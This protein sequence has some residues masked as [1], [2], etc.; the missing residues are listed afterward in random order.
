[1]SV[2]DV[3]AWFERDGDD[4][5]QRNL[6][7]GMYPLSFVQEAATKL[8]PDFVLG[9]KQIGSPVH[10]LDY[11]LGR[12]R[13]SILPFESLDPRR[14]HGKRVVT[15]YP[16][17]VYDNEWHPA[18]REDNWN[19][20]QNGSVRV[21]RAAV[22]GAVT[23]GAFDLLVPVRAHICWQP[24]PGHYK[25]LI[26]EPLGDF[27]DKQS[28]IYNTFAVMVSKGLG[29]LLQG[30]RSN[31]LSHQRLIKVGC[32]DVRERCD[33]DSDIGDWVESQDVEWVQGTDVDWLIL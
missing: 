5:Q 30:F 19:F 1:M 26:M 27:L 8:G 32:F 23:A 25:N 16:L 11:F 7:L 4:E 20:L 17:H 2:L 14:H 22:L 15:T 24:H 12:T 3:Q 29:L 21:K 9:R 31:R 10:S 33:T 18:C 13:G 6:V 28:K